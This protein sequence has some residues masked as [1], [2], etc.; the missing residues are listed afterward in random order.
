MHA[1][2]AGKREVD[3]GGL[4]HEKVPVKHSRDKYLFGLGKR[5]YEDEE[6]DDVS[7]QLS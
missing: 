6:D 5:F 3:E 7:G 2:D 1:D 4:M